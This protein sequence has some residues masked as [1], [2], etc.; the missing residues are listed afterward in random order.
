M[1]ECWV[2]QQEADYILL[3][4]GYYVCRS[5]IREGKDIL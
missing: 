2:C 1:N 5:C 3:D 4:G